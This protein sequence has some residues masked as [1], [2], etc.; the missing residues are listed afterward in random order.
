MTG[1]RGASTS[2]I[3]QVEQ[4]IRQALSI[5]LPCSAPA[6]SSAKAQRVQQRHEP[7]KVLP[8]ADD[9][10]DARWAMDSLMP[11]L[12]ASVARS[13]SFGKAEFDF[14]VTLKQSNDQ[15]GSTIKFYNSRWLGPS[16]L[17]GPRM[18]P[19]CRSIATWL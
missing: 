3:P 17:I 13:S 5:K 11:L 18:H 6:L 1:R 9:G 19:C 4:L 8:R 10:R 2:R 16:N 12:A 15:V 7:R 14:S